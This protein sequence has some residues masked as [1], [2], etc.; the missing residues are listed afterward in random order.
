MI[1][2]ELRFIFLVQWWD[3]F[4]LLDIVFNLIQPLVKLL[5]CYVDYT[6]RAIYLL[7]GGSSELVLPNLTAS[8]IVLAISCRSIICS[9]LYF[10]KWQAMV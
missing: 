3:L 4:I 9:I 8:S 5:Y 10:F 6:E 1:V 7:L 2:L